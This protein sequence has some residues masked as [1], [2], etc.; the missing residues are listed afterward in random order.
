MPRSAQQNPTRIGKRSERRKANNTQHPL[1]ATEHTGQNI[2]QPI[3]Q[4][5]I[6]ND[7]KNLNL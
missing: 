5:S 4:Y 3:R 2:D 1:D 7:H 6:E